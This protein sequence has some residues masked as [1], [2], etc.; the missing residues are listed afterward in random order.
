MT[1]YIY[2]FCH[3]IYYPLLLSQFVFRVLPYP[4]H[5]LAKPQGQ[6]LSMWVYSVTLLL[7]PSEA[8]GSICFI[9]AETQHTLSKSMDISGLKGDQL[10]QTGLTNG[11]CCEIHYP[12]SQQRGWRD[13]M[14]AASQWNHGKPLPSL[15]PVWNLNFW[16]V[17]MVNKTLTCTPEEAVTI[18]SAQHMV[19]PNQLTT[20]LSSKSSIVLKDSHSLIFA[21]I[22]WI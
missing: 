11:R 13:Y 22:H 7:A 18:L 14:K 12:L 19:C 2:M 6:P 5:E 3:T 20:D 9:S 15:W 16:S 8:M 17:Y 10:H 1:I 4:V 21:R